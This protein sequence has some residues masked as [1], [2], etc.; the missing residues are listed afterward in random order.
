MT[1][2]EG[3]HIVTRYTLYVGIILVFKSK[4]SSGFEKEL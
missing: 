4:G 1:A 2:S 3:Y